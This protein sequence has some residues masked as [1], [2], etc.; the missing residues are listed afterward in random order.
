M[1]DP[2]AHDAYL[3]AWVHGYD[4]GR[5]CPRLVAAAYKDMHAKLETLKA[6]FAEIGAT[7]G[8]HSADQIQGFG[9]LQDQGCVR[10]GLAASTST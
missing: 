6:H 7:P 2:P 5:W 9:C 10:P 3:H 1:W 8:V 4:K